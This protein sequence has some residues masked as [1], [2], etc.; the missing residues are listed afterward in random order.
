M[1]VDSEDHFF[2]TKVSK[3]YKIVI[4]KGLS[5]VVLAD[6]YNNHT[7]YHNHKP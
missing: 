5:L 3:L 1:I 2:P 6:W 4:E 7:Y